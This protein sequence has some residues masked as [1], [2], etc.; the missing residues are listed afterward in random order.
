MEK[1][2]VCEMELD[3]EM[4]R[5]YLDFEGRRYY[6]CSEGCRAEFMRHTTEYFEAQK[7]EEPA[8]DDV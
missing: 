7:T 2:V 1:D 3:S 4:V 8:R 6:F 5:A